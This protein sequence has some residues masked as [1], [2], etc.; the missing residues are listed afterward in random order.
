MSA[1]SYQCLHV[2]KH[3]I[4]QT[5]GCDQLSMYLQGHKHV[6]DQRQTNGW[7]QLSMSL[8]GSKHSID[9]YPTIGHNQLS[10]SVQTQERNYQCLKWDMIS[11]HSF[12]G[13]TQLL[14]RSNKSRV[15]SSIYKF[16]LSVCLYPINVKTAEPIGPKLFV[17]HLG[18]GL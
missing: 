13:R 10:M 3:I 5:N 6:I 7:D 4:D 16:G 1:I 8:Y 18:E 11:T 14:S 2:H 17:G 9:Q 15:F 12:R